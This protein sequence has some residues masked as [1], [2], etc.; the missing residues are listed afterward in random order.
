MANIPTYR[1]RDYT[2][3]Q[4]N[5]PLR[6]IRYSPLAFGAGEARELGQFGQ[7][8]TNFGRVVS[9]VQQY[10]RQD[11]ERLVAEK[12]TALYN[13]T[14]AE[15][16]AL[17]A[18]EYNRYSNNEIDSVE[19][20]TRRTDIISS[21]STSLESPEWRERY[22]TYN[23]GKDAQF[24]SQ[25]G[26]N[27]HKK[28]FNENANATTIKASQS[29]QELTD[30][31]I[32]MVMDAD[33]V[34]YGDKGEVI[35]THELYIMDKVGETTVAFAD[36]RIAKNPSL[37][38]DQALILAQQDISNQLKGL[39]KFAAE[40]QNSEKA[41][42]LY[43]HFSRFM[44]VEGQE[45]SALY[46]Q[47][48]A[49]R[50][51]KAL[52][53][54]TDAAY[55]QGA[56]EAF[57]ELYNDRGLEAARISVLAPIANNRPDLFPSIRSL[58]N[59]WATAIGADDVNK[60]QVERAIAITQLETISNNPELSRGER[61]DQVSKTIDES[62]ISATIKYGL[63]ESEQFD[64]RQKLG[65]AA[66]IGN[67]TIV[68]V[69][70]WMSNRIETEWLTKRQGVDEELLKSYKYA[71]SDQDWKN[72]SD[73]NK[74]GRFVTDEKSYKEIFKAGS[75]RDA[76]KFFM[77]YS[78][79]RNE[80][81]SFRE[82]DPNLTINDTNLRSKGLA[83]AAK[84]SSTKSLGNRLRTLLD[85]RIGTQLDYIRSEDQKIKQ[86]QMWSEYNRLNQDVI[87][88]S[89][90]FTPDILNIPGA[91]F[92]SAD[93]VNFEA[94]D[95]LSLYDNLVLGEAIDTST[96]EVRPTELAFLTYI[97]LIEEEQ[98]GNSVKQIQ[99][100]SPESY[101]DLLKDIKFRYYIDKQQNVLDL[102]LRGNSGY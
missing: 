41:A 98:K 63:D 99:G 81:D 50:E 5:A 48:A 25:I 76:D 14:V 10:R 43:G 65:K 82:D 70:N 4:R 78:R 36:A 34:I 6:N 85:P 75:G 22:I 60:L 26:S 39:V 15:T 51:A 101:Y 12:N 73:Y 90:H 55:K 77:A 67:E 64:M 83:I 18:T 20:G 16:N 47:D 95:S 53:P 52:K 31:A 28:A 32:N 96:I 94:Q 74:N 37:T 100:S 21:G 49:A 2:P 69:N 38:E 24:I 88:V 13:S 1:N 93:L 58:V 35:T 72:I 46:V 29:S 57:Q 84:Y 66:K 91:G 8:V 56:L 30:F 86:D 68:G 7:A 44:N 45:L 9:Q 3:Q 71:F 61:L 62:V 11:E 89:T 33:P 23:K 17:I 42:M 87:S 40:N 79:F 97:M 102:Y 19:F 54:S 92:S 59:G 27:E 80:M